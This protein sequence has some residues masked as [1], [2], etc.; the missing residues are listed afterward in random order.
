M[1]DVSGAETA[2]KQR[3]IFLD[4]ENTATAEIDSL[5]KNPHF[6]QEMFY[7][8]ALTDPLLVLDAEL[9]GIPPLNHVLPQVQQP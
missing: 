6:V 4:G 7:D 3:C 9:S 2:T 5:E 8:L 1:S